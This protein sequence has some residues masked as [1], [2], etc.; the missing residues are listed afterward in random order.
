MTEYIFHAK[1]LPT[2][3]WHI[4]AYDGGVEQWAQ[5]PEWPCDPAVLDAHIAR[6]AGDR[7]RRDLHAENQRLLDERSADRPEEET[8]PNGCVRF[9]D[10]WVPED[11]PEHLGV[12]S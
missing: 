11:C 12:G 5:P 9:G 1:Q 7:W 10:W 6:G 3:Y 4:R 8:C 2:G